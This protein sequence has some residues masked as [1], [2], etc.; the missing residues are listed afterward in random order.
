MATIIR[1]AFR[2]WLE[3][4]PEENIVGQAKSSRKCPLANFFSFK[5]KKVQITSYSVY[6]LDG[7]HLSSPPLW[8]RKFIDHLDT[9]FHH[10]LSLKV[11]AG[12]AL[13]TLSEI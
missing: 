10:K 7:V 1:K 6:S 3:A 5:G 12:L 9:S 11:S 8:M 2:E 4:F 13:R